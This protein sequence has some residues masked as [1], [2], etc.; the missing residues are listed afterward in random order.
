MSEQQNFWNN[1]VSQSQDWENTQDNSRRGAYV[2]KA[3]EE[4]AFQGINILDIGCGSGWLALQL[5]KFGN[6]TAVD[7]A[8]EVM[9]QLKQVHQQVAWIGGDFLSLELPQSHYDFAV[10]LETIAHVPDQMA[11]AN[12]MARL[13]RPG[14]TLVLT[15]QNEYVWR[16]TS[17][18]QP[19]KPGQLRNWPSRER[20]I[21][22]FSPWFSIHGI[23]TCAPGGDRGVPGLVSNRLS[24]IAGNILQGKKRWIEK[25]EQ[26]GF[27]RSLVLV[28]TRNDRA[29]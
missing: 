5:T 25:R 19:P 10:S 1:W 6:V 23:T 16:N 17:W 9:D 8:S 18:L 3:L 14:G 26:W 12:R 13:L 2:L 22:L 21:E 15:T 20:L 27:G 7:L 24:T 29:S 28:G 4:V 11:F